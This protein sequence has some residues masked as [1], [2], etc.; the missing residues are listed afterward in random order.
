MHKR[1]VLSL[2][3]VLLLVL[4]AWARVDLSLDSGYLAGNTTYQIGDSFYSSRTGSGTTHFPISELEFPIDAAVARLGLQTSCNNIEISA[5]AS[6]SLC[7]N[8]DKMKDSDWVTSSA[9]KDIYSESKRKLDY[10]EG[11]LK[12]SSKLFA[13]KKLDIKAGLGYTFQKFEFECRDTDQVNLTGITIDGQLV[14]TGHFAGKTISYEI[15][16]NIPYAELA[17]QSKLDRFDLQAACGY[18]P[19]VRVYDYDDHWLRNRHSSGKLDGHALLAN[20]RCSYRIC[21]PVSVYLSMDYKNIKA[22]GEQHQRG[23]D[24]LG[25]YYNEIDEKVKSRQ[26]RSDLGLTFHF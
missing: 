16:Y 24:S 17:L 19:Y 18:A 8:D 25:T 10:L 20:A 5:N 15:D 6:T 4:P 26:F 21:K 7:A 13:I 23:V 14:P 1:L 11:N 3:L 9:T 2:P 12:V 22:D